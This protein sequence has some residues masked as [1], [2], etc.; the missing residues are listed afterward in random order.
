MNSELGS[1]IIIDQNYEQKAFAIALEL[2][3][4]RV[5]T[6]LED[7]FKLEHAKAVIAESYISEQEVKTLIIATKNFNTVSQN[8]LLKLFEEPPRNIRFIIIVPSKSLLLPTIRS[9][10]PILKKSETY[11]KKEIDFDFKKIDNAKV[12]NFLK[13]YER[14]SKNDAQELLEALLY[15]AVSVDRVILTQGQLEAFDRSY[16]LLELNAR[17]QSVFTSLLL[18]FIGGIDAD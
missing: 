6:F 1:H 8:T 16:K 2:H 11:A 4:F 5:V 3:E 12:F 9:R 17:P 7:D 18:S 10:M 14:I 13:E 15:R